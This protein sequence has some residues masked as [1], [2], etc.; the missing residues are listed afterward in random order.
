M[1]HQMSPAL[2]SHSFLSIETEAFVAYR[3]WDE[4]GISRFLDSLE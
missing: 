4:G 3:N 2:R 1:T